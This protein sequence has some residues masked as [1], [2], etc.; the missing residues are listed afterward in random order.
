MVGG[1]QKDGQLK[2]K[3]RRICV[4]ES[5]AREKL[6]E[7]IKQAI[8]GALDSNAQATLNNDDA[9]ETLNNYAPDA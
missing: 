6:V 4:A 3:K 5:A 9:P 1:R 8:L 2:H 7:Q